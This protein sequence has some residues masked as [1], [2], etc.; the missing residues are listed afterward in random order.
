MCGI[1]GI[2][3]FDV[4]D[5]VDL[6]LLERMT[7]RISHR[8]PDN[9]G[10]FRDGPAGL[11]HRRLSIIDLGGG[12]Q[13]IF[14]EDGNV[15]VVFNGEIYN[16]QEISA[17]LIARGHVFRTHSDTEAI[18]HA[19]EQYGDNCV[20]LFRGMFAFA[21]WDRARHR[22]LLVRDRLG[23]KP[24]YYY[25][26]RDSLVFASEIKSLLKS[27]DV[28]REV[29]ET[30]LGLYLAQR[31]VPGPRT[32]FKN[33]FK[34]Q[35]GHM[36][37]VESGHVTVRKYWDI[38]YSSAGSA[39]SD[40]AQ[41]EQLLE[42]SV[43]LRLIAEVPLGVFLSG[44]LD[45][46]AILATMSRIRKGAP[47]KTFCVGYESSG[48]ADR[49]NEFVYA[50]EVAQRF[51]TEHY[52]FTLGAEDFRDFIPKL[53]WHL[54]EPLA[55]P[56]CIPLYFLSRLARQHITV[57]LSGEGADEVLGGY[58]IYSKM[59]ALENLRRFPGAGSMAGL[60]ARR[61]GAGRY[62]D[63]LRMAALP[64]EQRYRGV[65]RGFRPALQARLLG[66]TGPEGQEKWSDALDQIYT[67]LFAAVPKASSLDKM[68]YV[69]SKVWLPDDLLLKA[70]K[71]TMAN[72]L[73]LR[74]PF[75]DHKL[76]E[77]AA[78]L[79]QKMK[80]NGGT[81]KVLLRRIMKNVLPASILNRSKKGFPVPTMSWL[82]G[83]LKEFTRETLLAQ[84]SACHNYFDPQVLREIVD[85][86]EAGADRQQEI[87][88]LL[89]FEQW[90]RA[91]VQT[92]QSGARDVKMEESA[93]HPSPGSLRQSA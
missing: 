3:K 15:V 56:S 27:P 34:L 63:I 37:V 32:M 89:V 68:L 64:L 2:V 67:P 36:M 39:A 71:M 59:L 54:D 78:R 31:Y 22:L 9:F 13:P 14:N 49:D 33:I 69:D 40:P 76:V 48:G 87:W 4:N 17:D 11:G 85:Q 7:D 44:G 6:G 72:A 42:E 45:S 82:R 19:Y 20:K 46:S 80:L 25:Q 77:F 16:Y 91:F 70:D 61:F 93:Q 75:L 86:H 1:C 29:D 51:G 35:P 53:V 79:P 83:P 66:R 38:P 26:G 24:L 18:V 23:I 8:G 41:F 90:H 65:S 88:T 55:D 28:P 60:L 47:I 43:R 10:Y 12:R 81:G 5:S 52:E 92:S 73:E 21:L 62:Q 84:G 58:S 30:S 50:R 57:V 74:V